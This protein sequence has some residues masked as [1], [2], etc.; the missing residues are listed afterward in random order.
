MLLAGL[1]LA[2]ANAR[3]GGG[4]DDGILTAAEASYLDLD[5][6]DLVTLSACETAA[7]DAESGEGVLGLVAGFQ[8]AGAR[9][10]VASLWEVED[11]ATRH[12]MA[13]FYGL[14]RDPARPRTSAE[15]LREASLWL[16]DARPEG[17]DFRAA[18]YWAA[19]VGYARR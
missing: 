11:T 17:K 3:D 8:L 6:V 9:D 4:E 2:G 19:F 16:R 1:A 14:L 15:A 10:V 18:R 12:L 7:G 13:R 5:G